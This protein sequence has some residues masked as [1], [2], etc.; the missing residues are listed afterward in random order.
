M[1]QN[2]GGIELPGEVT[3]EFKHRPG[4]RHGNADAFSRFPCP[5]RSPGTACRPK[6]E[7]VVKCSS[8]IER[9]TTAFFD[10]P[11]GRPPG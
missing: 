7:T 2:A 5:L 8:S 10:E 9:P 4:L 11:A 1:G 6:D 3:F